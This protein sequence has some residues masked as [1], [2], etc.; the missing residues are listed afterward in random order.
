VIKALSPLLSLSGLSPTFRYGQKWIG[1]F[2]FETKSILVYHDTSSIKKIKK[3]LSLI[4][5]L[6]TNLKYLIIYSI[7]ML[8]FGLSIFLILTILL[9]FIFGPYKKSATF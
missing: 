2:L 4:W 6:H 1:L 3:K 9:N 8:I 5:L 7:H